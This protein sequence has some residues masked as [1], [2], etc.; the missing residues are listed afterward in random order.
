MSDI[1]H[2]A[3]IIVYKDG[4]RELL[5]DA[6]VS[7]EEWYNEFKQATKDLEKALNQQQRDTITSQ[8]EPYRFPLCDVG[9]EDQ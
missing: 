9:W 8:K 3:S 7:M 5:W 4:H 6:S 2:V 1:Q